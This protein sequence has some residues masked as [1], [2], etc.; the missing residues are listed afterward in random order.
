[1]SVMKGVSVLD[2]S[3]GVAGPM[4]GMMLADH[5]ASVERIVRPGGDP[6]SDFPGSRVWRR[7]KKETVL[8]LKDPADHAALLDRIR[9][10]D[11]LIESFAPKT[12]RDLG[13]EYS[14]L[15]ALN[16][17]LIHASVTA[18]GRDNPHADRPGYDSLVAARTGLQWEQRGWP[19]GAEAHMA[20][21]PGF[22]PDFTVPYKYVQGPARE[23]PVF[24]ASFQPS[25][26]AFFALLLGISAALRV[27]GITGKGQLVE[28]SLMRG[29]MAAA[30][31]VWQRAENWDEPGFATWIFG[32]RSPKGHF[33]CVDGKW[34]HQWVP[35]PRFILGADNSDQSCLDLQSDSDRFGLGPEELIVMMHY[36]DQL[37]EAVS[38]HDADWWMAA[39]ADAG[40][41]LQVCRPVEEALNDPLFLADGCVIERDDPDLGPVRQVGHCYSLSDC[42]SEIPG[43]P[44]PSQASSQANEEPANPVN[45]A[46]P[47]EGIRVLDFGLAVAGPYGTQQLADLGADVIKINQQHDDYWHRASTAMSCN[48]GKRSISI[49]LK[50]PDAQPVLQRLIA[51]ADV[52]QHNMRYS[53]AR[54][55]GIDYETLKIDH[56]GLIYCHTRGFEKGPR[57]G[58]P[59]NDQTGCALAGV[60]HENG[61]VSAG[62]K[63]IW[64][65]A[66]FGDTGNGFL[67]A[68]GI[69]QALSHRDRTGKGQ[70]VDTS[71][72]NA[73]LLATSYTYAFPD[74]SGPDR[75]KLDA[76]MLG[77]GALYRLYETAQGWLS[78]AVMKDSHWQALCGIAEFEQLA[79][80]PR[81]SS[82]AKRAE[83]DSA[84]SGFLEEQ[85]RT[86]TA[87]E[88]SG[89]LD[90]KG[91]PA[92]ISST[93]FP[94]TM[95]DD[96]LFLDRGW[97][98]RFDH[99]IAGRLEQPGLA[100][101]LSA[102]PGV[103]GLPPVVVGSHSRVILQELGLDEE[104]IE[105]LILSGVVGEASSD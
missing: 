76:D 28:T 56:P 29:A 80:D 105:S 25:L 5:G 84:L 21:Q 54:K 37:A 79:T 88:W 52:I 18:Y 97:I 49:N 3:S 45:L 92:E 50:H 34:I 10:A 22:A 68:I 4:T 82:A 73:C 41:P 66:S 93:E 15:A 89:I 57:E 96:A 35:N 9:D 7:G 19:E 14:A 70:F 72:M 44:S 16:P 38:H 32:S 23:G 85:F 51:S 87:N 17:R 20:R 90:S 74:G 67:S 99:P 48:R 104:A 63:P 71:I 64:N 94:H 27:R 69:V 1:M 26:G 62:G 59:G 2:L 65:L 83:H 58:L 81:F 40:V 11:V 53:A 24:N 100:V 46:R 6:Y 8:D 102:T 101:D 43:T 13:L 33:Q 39:G 12:A 75:Q 55:L 60:Q 78:L 47:L 31:G 98:A 91:V 77:L 86:R 61:A 36:Q 103:L 95:V 42:P 30:W